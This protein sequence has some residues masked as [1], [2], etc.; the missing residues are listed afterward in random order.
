MF[1]GHRGD[2]GSGLIGRR[3]QGRHDLIGNI[4]INGINMLQMVEGRQFRDDNISL[5]K[6]FFHGAVADDPELIAARFCLFRHGTDGCVEV[7]IKAIDIS[8]T[9][10]INGGNLFQRILQRWAVEVKSKAFPVFFSAHQ[11][12]VDAKDL[13]FGEMP[14]AGATEARGGCIRHRQRSYGCPHRAEK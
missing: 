1:V 6:H 12:A 7:F 11:T 14:K 4:A 5:Q 10:Q 8:G 2:F 13:L 3:V 9:L